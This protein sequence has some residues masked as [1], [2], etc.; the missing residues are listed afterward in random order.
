MSVIC[1]RATESCLT[2][3]QCKHS[4]VHDPN[5]C[6]QSVKYKENVWGEVH[7]DEIAYCGNIGQ[8]VQCVPLSN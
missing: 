6:E 2:V 8:D 4:I 3:L 5:V 7:Q 1:E